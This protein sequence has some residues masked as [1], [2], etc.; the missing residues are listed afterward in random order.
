M[1][2]TIFLLLAFFFFALEF[3]EDVFGD[4]D[5]K[6]SGLGFTS[7]SCSFSFFSE[8]SAGCVIS[9]KYVGH[10]SSSKSISSDSISESVNCVS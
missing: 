4:S 3:D 2:K 6:G 8:N 7:G 5:D 9:S 1:L 10:V